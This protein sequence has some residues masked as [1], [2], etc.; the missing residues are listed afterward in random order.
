MFPG[1]SC[2]CN[3]SESLCHQVNRGMVLVRMS[4]EPSKTSSTKNLKKFAKH[5]P[6]CLN[7]ISGKR[8]AFSKLEAVWK[9]SGVVM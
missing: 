7:N 4:L 5:W 3:G 2:L 6:E 1:E 9:E 8:A